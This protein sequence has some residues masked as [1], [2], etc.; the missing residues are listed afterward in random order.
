MPPPAPSLPGVVAVG[1]AAPRGAVAAPHGAVAAGWPVVAW[2][3]AVLPCP[4]PSLGGSLQ[5][6]GFPPCLPH[7]LEQFSWHA[8]QQSNFSMKLYVAFTCSLD[9]LSIQSLAVSPLIVQSPYTESL[10]SH[11]NTQLGPYLLWRR[12][13]ASQ[14]IGQRGE[15]PECSLAVY[16][17]PSSFQAGAS[18]GRVG[19]RPPVLQ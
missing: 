12:L 8:I 18:K 19:Q 10:E 15:P 4:V 7:H 9:L 1:R 14:Y 16:T 5:A 2:P 3:A 6:P 13:S 17:S 11:H